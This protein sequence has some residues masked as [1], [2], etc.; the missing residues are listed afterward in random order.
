MGKL[1]RDLIPQIIEASGRTPVTSVVTGSDLIKAL[2]DKLIEEA[3][4]VFDA[5][6]EKVI[7]ELADVQE[8]I[9]A[10]ISELKIDE[11]ELKQLQSAKRDER[12]GFGSGIILN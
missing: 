9:A 1:V 12:G 8:V 5:P 3:Q 2:K 7:E 6:A 11:Q 4:E 10:L